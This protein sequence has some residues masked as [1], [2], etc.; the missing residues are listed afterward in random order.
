MSIPKIIYAKLWKDGTL[1]AHTNE[2]DTVPGYK[3]YRI[4]SDFEVTAG[5]VKAAMLAVAMEGD[6][7][8]HA[9]APYFSAIAAQ[10]NAIRQGGPNA[11]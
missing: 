5:Q 10:L 9:E 3:E 11:Q 4:A 7:E 1:N 2:G 6:G 8:I